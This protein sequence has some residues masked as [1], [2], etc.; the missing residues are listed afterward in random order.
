MFN[1]SFSLYTCCSG[2]ASLGRLYSSSPLESTRWVGLFFSSS[3]L[4]RS[5][6]GAI[7]KM[8]SMELVVNDEQ[9]ADSVELQ[10]QATHI[11][12]V[13]EDQTLSA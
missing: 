5:S 7:G 4:A 1:L 12:L 9:V 11:Q 8:K 3:R 13:E 2:R 6:R 10:N